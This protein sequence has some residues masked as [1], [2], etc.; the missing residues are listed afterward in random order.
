MKHVL[1]ILLLLF[2]CI[3]LFPQKILAKNKKDYWYR[4]LG[5][6]VASIGIRDNLMIEPNTKILSDGKRYDVSIGKRISLLHSPHRNI[7]KLGW[8]FGISASMT[9]SLRLLDGKNEN[10]SLIIS[11]EHFEGLF[12]L[13][14][15]M[16]HKSWLLMAQVGHVSSHLVDN[17][18]EVL[19]YIIYSRFWIELTI[20]KQFP[21]MRNNYKWRLYLQNSIGYNFKTEPEKSGIRLLTGM[22]LSFRLGGIRALS[23][24]TSIDF[25]DLGVREQK[26]HYTAFLGVGYP[27][28]FY[29]GNRPWRFGVSYLKGGDYRNQFYQREDEY[30]ALTWQMEL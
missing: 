3:G 27:K 4:S 11:T 14:W 22:D 18:L 10:N 25:R 17:N 9:A 24:I 8:S 12:G 16:V 7:K 20:G 2:T 19:N 15:G 26:S 13:Y 1:P 23:L 29:L 6:W 5:D 21:N 28:Y 30:M